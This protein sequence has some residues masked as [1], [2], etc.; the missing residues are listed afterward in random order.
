MSESTI[1]SGASIQSKRILV[2]GGTSGMGQAIVEAFPDFGAQVV[3]FG[4]NEDKGH[5][6]AEAT[7]ATFYPVDVTDPSGV[8]RGIDQ[9]ADLLGGLDILIHAS[10]IAPGQNAEDIT[11]AQWNEVMTTNATGTFLTN[12]HVFPHLKE[13]GGVILNFSSA[14]G[15][16]GYAGKAHYA[17]SKGAV[18]AWVR[19]VAREWAPY[20]IRVNAIAPAIWTPMYDKTRA[21]M[22]PEQLARHD[23]MLKSAIPLGGKLGDVKQD[24]IP[25]MRFLSSD[26]ARFMTGQVFAIDGGTLMLR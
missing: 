25:I 5:A 2:T 18:T 4:R 1:E 12:V 19:S 24:F 21:A 3:F 22:S 14:G 8:E 6:L 16:Q 11:L 20:N 26:D 23:E 15:I 7:G 9:A 13:Q 10:G 17:A